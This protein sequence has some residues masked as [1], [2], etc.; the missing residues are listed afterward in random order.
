[1]KSCNLSDNPTQ[2]CSLCYHPKTLYKSCNPSY[3]TKA[4]HS[5]CHNLAT[6]Y[7]SCNPC[8]RSCNLKLTYN[9]CHN[10]AAFVTSCLQTTITTPQHHL[11]PLSPV[12]K[13]MQSCNVCHN[14]TALVIP[15]NL[16]KSHN[17][18]HNPTPASL[19]K[20]HRVVQLLSQH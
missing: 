8:H 11:H 4:S 13:L 12:S 5:L 2:S 15:H 7:T 9:P 19:S 3:K 17:T 14:P 20:P 6:S 10:S 1:M 18:Y 16:S